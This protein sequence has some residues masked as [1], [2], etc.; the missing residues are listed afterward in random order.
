MKPTLPY[1]F[2]EPPERLKKARLDNI[3]LV[4]ASLL[5]LKGTYQVLANRLPTGSVLVVPGTPRQKKRLILNLSELACFNRDSP[6]KKA[7]VLLMRCASLSS[8]VFPHM[9]GSSAICNKKRQAC[10]VLRIDT[11]IRFSAEELNK[12]ALERKETIGNSFYSC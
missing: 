5:P 9:P 7:R 3:A 4:P 2:S 8:P 1:R 10:I 12:R 6:L 11:Y